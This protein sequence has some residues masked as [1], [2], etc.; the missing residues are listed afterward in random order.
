MPL[1]NTAGLTIIGD[2]S[3]WFWA[4]AGFF[5]IPIT[6][7]AIYSQ[8]RAQRSAN[9]VAALLALRTEWDSERML[10]QRLAL[11]L[12]GAEGKPGWPP[13][14][15]PV[16]NFFEHLGL[17]VDYGDVGVDVVW[18][19]WRAPIQATWLAHARAVV[20]ERKNDPALWDRWEGLARTMAEL[21]R[22][23]RLP[24]LDI[25]GANATP[26]WLVANL[27]ERLRLEQEAKA[28]VIPTWSAAQPAE[29]AEA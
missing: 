5:A 21:D 14:L 10:R 20:E 3:Q 26:A 11:L 13:A 29:E 12:H 25:E 1:I 15:D 16:G 9:R 24:P 28:G 7:Y 27:I 2:G 18:D 22:R 23:H 4:M 6:G 17:L 8:L 19:Q